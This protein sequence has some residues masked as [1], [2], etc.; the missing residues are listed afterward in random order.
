MKLA[1]RPAMRVAVRTGERPPRTNFRQKIF[2]MKL[3]GPT[4][5]PQQVRGNLAAKVNRI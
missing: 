3:C 4:I 5:Q 2:L 1:P